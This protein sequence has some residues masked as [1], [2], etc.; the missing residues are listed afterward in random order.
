[1]NEVSTATIIE[2]GCG[3]GHGVHLLSEKNHNSYGID[4][5]VSQIQKCVKNYPS[6]ALKFKQGLSNRS[7]F[8]S[9]TFNFAIS[10]EAAQ[11]FYSFFDFAQESYRILKEDGVLAITTFFLL[12]KRV[13]EKSK[14]SFLKVL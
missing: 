14:I 8:L 4:L 2:I 11:H 9:N 3:R 7:G 6:L 5:V 10:I 12:R 1:M 13:K